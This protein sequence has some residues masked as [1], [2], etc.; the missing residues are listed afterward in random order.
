MTEEWIK[1]MWCICTMENYSAKTKN[2][3]VPFATTGLDIQGIMLSDR[4]Q[5]EKNQ[6]CI[7]ALRYRM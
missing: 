5:P 6:Y 7:T 2:E 3:T 1:K 4:R